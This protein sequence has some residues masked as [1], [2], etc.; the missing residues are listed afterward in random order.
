M[1]KLRVR[2]A[3]ILLAGVCVLGLVGDGM[4]AS[5][6]SSK[7]TNDIIKQKEEQIKQAEKEKQDI[8]SSISDIKAIKKQLEKEKKDLKNYISQLDAQVTEM[9]EKIE[10]L[11]QEICEKEEE[12]ENTR[13]ELVLAIE[14]EQKQKDAVM[15][16]IKIMY[17]QKDS[18]IMELL[19]NSVGIGDM[20]N[21]AS[22]METIA[23]YD[24]EQWQQLIAARKMI[25]ICEK[26]LEVQVEYLDEMK[27]AVEEEQKNLEELIAEKKLDVEAYE[28]D[29]QQQEAAIKAEEEELA[30]QEEVIRQLEQAIEEER[31]RLEEAERLKYDGGV[32]AFPLATYTRVTSNFGP[33]THPITG[34]PM[35]MHYGVDLAAPKG[36]DIYAAYGGKVVASTYHYSMGN[37]VMIDHGDDLYTIYMHASKLIAKKGDVVTRGQ[38]IA[39]VGTTGSSTGYHLHFGVRLNGTYV[40][41]WNYLSK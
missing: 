9:E 14:E 28:D 24:K 3:G 35:T 32:F 41:P 7:L 26:Q 40:N 25:A 34:K 27:A 38:K 4:N 23:N 39:E 30:A 37:Y 22:Y 5:A 17:E 21:K 2:I 10:G 16:H 8:K 19:Q 33:R 6:A 31:K 12:L 11:K 1:Y 15:T 20:L 13:A 18:Y 36:T 29:I